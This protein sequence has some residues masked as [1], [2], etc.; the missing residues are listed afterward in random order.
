MTEHYHRHPKQRQ[1]AAG[2]QHVH[3]QFRWDIQMHGDA[4][5]ARQAWGQ[6][7]HLVVDGSEHLLQV[8]LLWPV[9]DRA[10]DGHGQ[11]TGHSDEFRPV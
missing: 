7:D 3:R 8:P 11:E 2:S 4:Q 6:D 1:H 10:T 9:S 5:D